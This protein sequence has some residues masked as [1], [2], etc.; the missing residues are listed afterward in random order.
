MQ[1][2]HKQAQKTWQDAPIVDT[3]AGLEQFGGSQRAHFQILAMFATQFLP[4]CRTDIARHRAAKSYAALSKDVHA[5]K[6]ASGF[7]VV[8]RIFKLACELQRIMPVVEQPVLAE[9]EEDMVAKLLDALDEEADA[10]TRHYE[11]ELKEQASAAKKDEDGAAD[12]DAGSEGAAADAADAA[13]AAADDLSS[14]GPRAQADEKRLE[15]VRVLYAEDNPFCVSVIRAYL[16]PCGG[17]IVSAGDGTDVVSKLVSGREKFDCVLMDCHMP[18]MDGFQALKVIRHWETDKGHEPI[19]IIGIT[20]YAGHRDS[21][22]DGGMTGFLTKPVSRP[23][24]IRTIAACLDGREVEEVSDEDGGVGNT[25]AAADGATAANGG[26]AAGDG[27]AGPHNSN[28]RRNAPPVDMVAGTA[29]FG[30][31]DQYLE[32]LVRFRHSFAP[33]ARTRI[34]AA[35]KARERTDLDKAVHMLKGSAGYVG[36]GTLFQICAETRQLLAEPDVGWASAQQQAQL[37]LA[38]VQRA[39]E[40]LDQDEKVLAT[41][42]AQAAATKA[43]AGAAVDVADSESSGETTE[44]SDVDMV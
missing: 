26:A 23:T 10:F 29:N 36:A 8:S 44:G 2:Q 5:L 4:T 3:A 42:Q 38:E 39:C 18:V 7:A 40:F 15:G 24:L 19:P 22:L 9:G 33:E 12:S 28:A 14:A 13:D 37:V 30:S 31:E 1:R 41:F 11:N 25:G 34:S 16:D 17:T 6:G 27:G 20:A 32:L 35:L 21:M 43:A